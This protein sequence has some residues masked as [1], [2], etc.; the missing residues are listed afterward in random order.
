MSTAALQH[1]TGSVVKG[2]NRVHVRP[3]LVEYGIMR[4]PV[5][6]DNDGIDSFPSA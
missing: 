2:T 4:D 3:D 5:S 6:P 1:R